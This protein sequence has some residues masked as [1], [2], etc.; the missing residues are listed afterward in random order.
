MEPS[1]RCEIPTKKGMKLQIKPPKYRCPCVGPTGK[2]GSFTS[3][4]INEIQGSSKASRS[5]LQDKLT[6]LVPL[7]NLCGK[8]AKISHTLVVTY[9]QTSQV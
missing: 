3:K 2:Q 5:L 9:K 8:E 1:I 7:T 4:V 6:P